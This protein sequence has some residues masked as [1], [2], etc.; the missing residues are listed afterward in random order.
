[1]TGRPSKPASV[2]CPYCNRRSSIDL[3]GPKNNT[4]PHC[5]SVFGFRIA[6]TRVSKGQRFE[7]AEFHASENLKRRQEVAKLANDEIARGLLATPGCKCAD[8][9]K[10]SG[11]GWVGHR[12]DGLEAGRVGKD[13]IEEPPRHRIMCPLRLGP[14]P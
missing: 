4:C 9:R 10:F 13:G 11:A 3:N 2:P 1:M 5:D 12:Q 8:A 6:T 14:L 7:L